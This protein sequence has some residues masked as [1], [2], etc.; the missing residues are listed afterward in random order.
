MLR[1]Y[2][3][4]LCT[5]A[6]HNQLSFSTQWYPC[7][8]NGRRPSQ[9]IIEQPPFSRSAKN[10]RSPELCGPDGATRMPEAR[11]MPT[12][13]R[14]A[15][16]HAPECTQ[17]YF[18]SLLATTTCMRARAA[19]T[20]V[21]YKFMKP[22]EHCILWAW[23]PFLAAACACC[24]P[25]WPK[26]WGSAR[27]VG[28]TFSFFFTMIPR[29]EAPERLPVSYRMEKCRRESSRFRPRSATIRRRHSKLCNSY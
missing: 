1:T 9:D 24:Y 15:A 28:V 20:R 10:G 5:Y 11:Y 6:P 8:E 23:R 7:S 17:L 21:S 19:C 26:Q 29:L 3:P 14:R 25:G 18:V 13:A 2:A 4:H 22:N 27:S 12:R 16:A